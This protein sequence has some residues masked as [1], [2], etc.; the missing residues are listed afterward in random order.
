MNR[1][2][3]AYNEIIVDFCGYGNRNYEATVQK[4]I[5]EFFLYYD[6][7]FAP[8][9]TIITMDYPTICPVSGKCGI[10]PNFG[11]GLLHECGST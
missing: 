2:Q 3:A 11:V 4:A 8:Q 5:P 1:T 9:E 7:Q 10:G 6:A